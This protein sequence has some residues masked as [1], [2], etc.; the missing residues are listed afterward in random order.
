MNG[1]FII[2]NV[3]ISSISHIQKLTIL[4]M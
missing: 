4:S 1:I 3:Q 2:L